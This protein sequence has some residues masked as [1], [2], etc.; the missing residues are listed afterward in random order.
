MCSKSQEP[1]KSFWKWCPQAYYILVQI[2]L[3]FSFVFLV[4]SHF[5]YIDDTLF[6]FFNIELLPIHL[7]LLKEQC[8][9]QVSWKR[10][11]NIKHYIGSVAQMLSKKKKANTNRATELVLQQMRL[12]YRRMGVCQWCI[13][14]FSFEK[15]FFWQF[16]SIP[17]IPIYI[18][19]PLSLC[20]SQ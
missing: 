9:C 3:H 16:F 12:S 4:H 13:S 7:C 17:Q 14:Y 5:K 15:C 20:R 11:L 2:I 18:S 8:L 19:P 10:S 6:F 1:E